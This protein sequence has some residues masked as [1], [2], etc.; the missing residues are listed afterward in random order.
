[1]VT[2]VVVV[3][4]MV[5]LLVVIGNPLGKA[6]QLWH[7]RT[8]SFKRQEK[9]QASNENHPYFSLLSPLSRTSCHVEPAVL[10]FAPVKSRCV[11]TGH[12]HIPERPFSQ[13]V[14][15]AKSGL[16]HSNTLS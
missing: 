7:G 1:M 4:V 13:R 11:P 12:G 9:N 3:V 16:H 10:A 6:H 14:L 2:V 5:V 8:L 15:F